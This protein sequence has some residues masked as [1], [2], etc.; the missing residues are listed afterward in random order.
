MKNIRI[1]AIIG[2]LLPLLAAC[3]PTAE[4]AK[5]SSPAETLAKASSTPTLTPTSTPSPTPEVLESSLPEGFQLARQD[6]FSD[7]NS[8]WPTWDDHGGTGSYNDGSF[9]IVLDIPDQTTWSVGGDVYLDSRVQVEIAPLEGEDFVA[10]V[11]CRYTDGDNNAGVLI[12]NT[13]RFA[14][15]RVVNGQGERLSSGDF[16][17]AILGDDPVQLTFDCIGDSYSVYINGHMINTV[18]AGNVQP[19]QVGMLVCSC[20]SEPTSIQFD[21]M[22]IFTDPASAI[23]PADSGAIEIHANL[24]SGEPVEG[25][26]ISFDLLGSNI[27]GVTDEN[28]VVRITNLE[29]GEYSVYPFWIRGVTTPV[30]CEEPQ[31]KGWNQLSL[32]LNAGSLGYIFGQENP[33]TLHAGGTLITFLQVTCE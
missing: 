29:P 9:Q 12:T 10:G 22:L 20:A 16:D 27:V 4:P 32:I 6:D 5:A 13:G 31:I 18:Q 30:T 2:I 28:G 17:P 33:M 24:A 23:E 26:R 3:S 25:L 1:I 7:P 8:G 15:S 19:G 14:V 21:N 11:M